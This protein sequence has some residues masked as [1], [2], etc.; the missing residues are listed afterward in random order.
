MHQVC[1]LLHHAFI[2]AEIVLFCENDTE[3]EDEFIAIVARRLHT[4]WIAQDTVSISADLQQVS[5]ELL[6][7][8]HEE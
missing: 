7:G 5:A 6:A 8:D 4:D 3:I 1:Y 2:G